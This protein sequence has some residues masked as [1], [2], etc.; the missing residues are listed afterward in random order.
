MH[1]PPISQTHTYLHCPRLSREPRLSL[2][3]WQGPWPFRP[4]AAL[5]RGLSAQRPLP[6][7]WCSDQ[8]LTFDAFSVTFFPGL[9]PSQSQSLLRPPAPQPHPRASLEPAWNPKRWDDGSGFTIC[10]VVTMPHQVRTWLSR[11]VRSPVPG[12]DVHER[13]LPGPGRA[14]D[15]HQLPT[16][17]FPRNAFQ[18]G[19][20]SCKTA[21]DIHSPT[22]PG[23]TDWSHP[24]CHTDKLVTHPAPRPGDPGRGEMRL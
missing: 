7:S 6:L 3:R 16:V 18:K 24:R 20:V 10:V 15:G 11:W 14:H 12:Q 17:E 5:P 2:G 13:G 8:A 4:M 1:S 19:L 21:D 23:L 22:I 9:F